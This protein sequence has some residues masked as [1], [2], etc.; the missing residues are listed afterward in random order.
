MST[1]AGEYMPK[2]LE[3]EHQSPH[4]DSS[5]WVAVH[6]LLN[7]TAPH[8]EA[9]VSFFTMAWVIG[10]SLGLIWVLRN[11]RTVFDQWKE[12][13]HRRYLVI[14]TRI[15]ARPESRPFAQNEP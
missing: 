4:I 3:E 10:I 2:V 1:D 15:S 7:P 5:K 6:D 8:A 13:M 11:G 12:N 14:H 9:R